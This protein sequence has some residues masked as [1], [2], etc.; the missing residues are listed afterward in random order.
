IAQNPNMQLILTLI[1]TMIACLILG[2]GSPTSANYIITSTIALPGII[3]LNEQLDVSIPVLAAHMFVF[4]FGIIA[5]I[6]PPVA[7]AAFAATGISQGD[8]KSTRLNSSHV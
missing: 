2:M 3:A 5:D 7:I 6:T 1:F 4:Y 8:R